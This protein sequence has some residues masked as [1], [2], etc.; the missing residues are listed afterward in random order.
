MQILK[1]TPHQ[2]DVDNA[3]DYLQSREITK[4]NFLKTTGLKGVRQAKFPPSDLSGGTSNL[5]L[6]G[7]LVSL[8]EFFTTTV[9]EHEKSENDNFSAR[10]FHKTFLTLALRNRNRFGPISEFHT[11][12]YVNAYAMS[13]GNTAMNLST[14]ELTGDNAKDFIETPSNELLIQDS[15]GIVISPR[16]EHLDLSMEQAP[17]AR[18]SKISDSGIHAMPPFRKGDVRM[19]FGIATIEG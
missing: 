11:D 10:S 14:V 16:Y 1:A 2:Q 8:Q 3:I 5:I 15:S 7:S 17:Q 12:S 9:G 6:P 19:F 4:K 18:I 13:I